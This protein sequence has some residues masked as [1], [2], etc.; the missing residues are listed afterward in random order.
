MILAD[1]DVL[2]DALN[3]K[4]PSLGRITLEIA[5]GRL[6]TTSITVFELL[7]GAKRQSDRQKI[8][9]LLDAMV[10]LPFDEE[11]SVKAAEARVCLESAGKG[12]GTADYLIAGIVLARKAVLLTRNRVHFERI[13][14]LQLGTLS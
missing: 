5:T 11:A 6:A 10:V 8:Q 9:K 13:P 14:G 3:G 7:S 4:E 2:I 12:I 1:T